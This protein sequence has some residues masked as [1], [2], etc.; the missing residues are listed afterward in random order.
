[1][2]TN[3][4]IIYPELSYKLTGLFF[5]THNE[6][7]LYC[8]EKQYGDLLEKKL[9]EVNIPYKREV[10]IG[11]TGNILD[12]VIDNKIILELKA[13][14]VITKEMYRQTQNYLQ[15]SGLGLGLIVNFRSQ[16][17]KPVRIVRIDT[18]NKVKY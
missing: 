3:N 12:F 16:Y 15:Q 1:M 8:R 14:R 6:L 4:K 17:L 5:E 11:D 13:S 9:N 2:D 18:K 10:S 7:G